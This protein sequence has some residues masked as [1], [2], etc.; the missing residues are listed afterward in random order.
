MKFSKFAKIM[1][2]FSLALAL[3]GN[4]FAADTHKAN[5]QIAESVQVNGTELAP[6]DYVAKWAG[7]GPDVQVSITRNGKEVATVPAKLVQLSQKSTEDS[8]EVRN[9]SGGR[10]LNTL[11]FAGKKYA[12]EIGSGQ[13]AA[14]ASVK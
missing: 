10:E 6:G 11:Q 9:G 2:M 8:S 14:T 12:L 4:G 13:T 7:D 1:M 3:A 5:F